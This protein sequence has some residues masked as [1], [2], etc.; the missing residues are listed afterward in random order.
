MKKDKD[1]FT[2]IPLYNTITAAK[3][4]RI[5][6][7]RVRRW[8]RGYEYRYS[9]GPDFELRRGRKGPIIKRN[10]DIK[11]SYASFLDLIDMLFV[12]KFL[13]VYA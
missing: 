3:L 11:D 2:E 4:S 6:P 1:N 12:K 13:L 8:L 7:G 9:A 10:Y 5:S